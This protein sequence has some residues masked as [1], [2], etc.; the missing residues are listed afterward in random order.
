MRKHPVPTP[1][2][3]SWFDGSKL[4]HRDLADAVAH[5]ARMLDLHVRTVHDTWGIAD[6]LAVSLDAGARTV[7]V[8]AGSAYTCRGESIVLTAA[9]TIAAPPASVAGT[10]FD[11]E[12]VPVVPADG[13]TTPPTDCGGEF[14]F[15][16]ATLRW[17][18]VATGA[19]ATHCACSTSD[20]VHLARF[21]RLAGGTL[22][23]PDLS[24]RRSV[25]ALRRPHIATGVAG[26]GSLN[27][28]QGTAHLVATIDTSAAGFTSTPTYFASITSVVPWQGAIVGPFLSIGQATRTR[29]DVHLMLAAKPPA[30]VMMF[31]EVPLI[32]ALEIT[33]TGIESTS[34]CS[35]GLASL[36]TG[37]GILAASSVFGVTP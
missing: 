37:A 36:F 8:S 7:R 2:R 14:V 11:L 32:E 24:R 18:S 6:G 1:R 19:S 3:V 13:C 5:E 9:V 20:A 10:V 30:L 15:P 17:T 28:K 35:D 27:W 34:G 33:W 23:G 29:F 12:L 26:A 25:R 31:A 16:H 22:G 21:T 4:A